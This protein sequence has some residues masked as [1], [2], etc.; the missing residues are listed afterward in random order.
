MLYPYNEE[1]CNA[2]SSPNN[3]TLDD[4]IQGG[5]AGQDV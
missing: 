5:C 3:P 2:C 1:N 4:E